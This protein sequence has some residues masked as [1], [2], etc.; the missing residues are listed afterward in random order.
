MVPVRVPSLPTKLP[1]CTENQ[2]S[3]FWSKMSV[4]GSRASGVGIMYFSMSPV[5]GS[6]RPMCIARLPAYHTNPS[7]STIRLCGPVPGSSS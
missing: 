6:S 7:S 2:M 3:P 5:S 1:P 4:W